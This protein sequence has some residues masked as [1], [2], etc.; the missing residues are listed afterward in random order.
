MPI[1]KPARHSLIEKKHLAD[2][3]KTVV[4]FVYEDDGDVPILNKFLKEGYKHVYC[5]KF[6]GLFWI[7]L[8]FRLDFAEC[9]VLPYDYRDTIENVL[10]GLDITLY[11]RVESW[12]KVRRYR[13]PTVVAPYTCVEAMKAIVGVFEPFVFTPYQLFNFVE[14]QDGRIFWR[15]R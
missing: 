10:E 9:Y 8:D 11:Q 7:K 12:R 6:D 3:S 5:V 1:I 14:K 15:R 2:R 13:T 4:Y